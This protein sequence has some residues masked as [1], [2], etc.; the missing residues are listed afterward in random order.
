MAIL[1]VIVF[2]S[3][4]GWL[5]SPWIAGSAVLLAAGHIPAAL[6]IARSVAASTR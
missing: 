1:P 6:V 2:F 3:A 5:G 4:A